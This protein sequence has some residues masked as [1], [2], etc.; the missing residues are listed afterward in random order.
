MSKAMNHT[1]AAR[2]LGSSLQA[3]ALAGNFGLSIGPRDV[4]VGYDPLYGAFTLRVGKASRIVYLCDDL[5]TT[6]KGIE[7]TVRALEQ[8]QPGY[9]ALMAHR[10]LEIHPIDW[11]RVTA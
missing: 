1:A 9:A 7:R 11:T 6:V 2:D 8:D 10:E 4:A 5:A 3:L